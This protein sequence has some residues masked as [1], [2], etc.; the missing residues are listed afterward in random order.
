MRLKQIT[1]KQAGYIDWYPGLNASWVAVCTNPGENVT[2]APVLSSCACLERT[3]Y[4]VYIYFN[5][6]GGFCV[7]A[8]LCSLLSQLTPVSLKQKY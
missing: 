2:P 6:L 7:S 1:V 5:I 8:E 4:C 3:G